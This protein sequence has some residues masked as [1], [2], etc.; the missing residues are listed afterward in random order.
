MESERPGA[1]RLLG[2]AVQALLSSSAQTQKSVRT[3]TWRRDAVRSSHRKCPVG[4]G[5]LKEVSPALGPR[6]PALCPR[7]TLGP[8]HVPFGTVAILRRP[9]LGPQESRGKVEPASTSER[10]VRG[11]HSYR[12]CVPT[13]REL[14]GRGRGGGGPAARI[15]GERSVLSVSGATPKAASVSGPLLPVRRGCPGVRPRRV[16]RGAAGFSEEKCVPTTTGASSWSVSKPVIPVLVPSLFSLVISVG[17][18]FPKWMSFYH[19]NY[20]I[21]KTRHTSNFPNVHFVFNKPTTV[22]M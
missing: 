18:A 20:R 19:L 1:R 5:P 2:S 17:N 13:S 15:A 4:T 6:C 9:D 22:I 14:R 3:E 7:Q 10:E 8:Y 11:F 21:S 16:T 12:P